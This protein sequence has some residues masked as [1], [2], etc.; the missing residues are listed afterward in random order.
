VT[1]DM[2]WA[3]IKAVTEASP[4]ARILFD[5]FQRLGDDELGKVRGDE[6][7]AAN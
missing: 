6:M 7:R 4:R 5:I 2:S 1:I 3:N